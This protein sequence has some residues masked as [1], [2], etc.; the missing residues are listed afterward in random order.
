MLQVLLYDPTASDPTHHSCL[1]RI[2][3][4]LRAFKTQHRIWGEWVFRGKYFQL[5]QYFLS[6]VHTIPYTSCDPVCIIGFTD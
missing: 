6:K 2:Q 1:S 4:L 5:G 3:D